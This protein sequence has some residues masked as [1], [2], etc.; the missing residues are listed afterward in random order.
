MTD[1]TNGANGTGQEKVRLKCDV[2]VHCGK[3]VPSYFHCRGLYS[4]AQGVNVYVMVA[5]AKNYNKRCPL[6]KT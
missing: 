4:A 3:P 6:L 2:K 1:G 5:D